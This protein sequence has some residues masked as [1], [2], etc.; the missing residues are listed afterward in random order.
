MSHDPSQPLPGSP[1]ETR[2]RILDACREVYSTWGYRGTRTR[3]VADRAGVNEATVFRHF[4][5]K[6]GLIEAMFEDV[7]RHDRAS[8]DFL[9]G[10]SG[11]IVADLH[12]LAV[13][14]LHGMNAKRDLILMALAEQPRDPT[15]F[16]LIWKTPALAH[17]R[18]TERFAQAVASGVV[19]GDPTILARFFMGALFAHVVGRA[20]YGPSDF[21][22][23]A[24]YT[25]DIFLHGIQT[26]EISNAGA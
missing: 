6:E 9:S 5:T 13:F 7:S 20:I 2:A 17:R 16:N 25:V 22:D 14:A 19:R 23:V 10:S 24:T 21:D 3:E 11:N 4:G 12:Q 15:A 26:K 18:L 8:I 1:Q